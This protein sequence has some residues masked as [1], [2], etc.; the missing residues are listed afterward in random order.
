MFQ[1]TKRVLIERIQTAQ[2]VV[3]LTG[4]GISAE[5]GIPTFRG[6][7]GLWKKFSPEELANFEAFYSNPSMVSEWYQY[8][9]DIILSKKPNSA[10]F[11]PRCSRL[12]INMTLYLPA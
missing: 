9:R 4:A 8:R 3:V 5:S 10:H 12:K 7:D 6:E 2:R 1:E 11:P